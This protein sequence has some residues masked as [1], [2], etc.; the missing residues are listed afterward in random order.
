MA[1]VDSLLLLSDAQA[2]TVDAVSEN[3]IDLTVARNLSAHNQPMYVVVIVDT[4]FAGGTSLQIQVVTDGDAA[5]G[6]PVVLAQSAVLL[7]AVLLAGRKPIVIP[8]GDPAD[9][10]ERYLGINYNQDGDF[11]GGAVT[12]FL[13][14]DPPNQP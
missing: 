7:P 2:I 1:Y 9:I 14:V 8:I 6:S 4:T 5:L 11:T 3:T 13:T 12:A 10:M